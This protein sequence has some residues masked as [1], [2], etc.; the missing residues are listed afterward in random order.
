MSGDRARFH[1]RSALR[2]CGNT[3]PSCFATAAVAYSATGSAPLRASPQGETWADTFD[4]GALVAQASG[5]MRASAPTRE[6]RSV[7][8]AAALRRRSQVDAQCAPL[9]G[10]WR[11]AFCRGRCLHRPETAE[12]GSVRRRHSGD[13]CLQHRSDGAKGQAGDPFGGGQPGLNSLQRTPFGRYTPTGSA[14][15]CRALASISFRRFS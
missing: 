14:C 2:P 12:G 9:R 11:R 4:G 1:R 7:H 5:P 8:S 15:F 13:A 6:R 10:N 3:S